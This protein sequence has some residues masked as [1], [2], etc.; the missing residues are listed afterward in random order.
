MSR[1]KFW[2]EI[3][4]YADNHIEALKKIEKMME[5]VKEIGR[6]VENM[7]M[8]KNNESYNPFIQIDDSKCKKE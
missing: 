3:Y 8:M 4:L 6:E 2:F 7:G 1:Y 5:K